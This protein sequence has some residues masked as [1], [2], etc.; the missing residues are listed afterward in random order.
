M[1]AF[2]KKLKFVDPHFCMESTACYS[3]NAVE[4]LHNSGFKVSVVNPLQIKSFRMSKMVRQKTDSSDA[5]VIANF[6]LQ[7]N[8]V[9]WIPRPC[10]NKELSEINSRLDSMKGKLNR[11]TNRLEKKIL[12]V[13][14]KESI[15]EEIIFLENRIKILE[16]EAKKLIEGDENLRCDFALLTSVKGVGAK[17]VLQILADMPD[18]NR[19]E[20][21]K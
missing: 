14:V 17:T 8:P 13:T 18:V 4:F 10:Q 11:L 6:C 1:I 7:N 3:E 5:E 20:N 16:N 12:N 19:F 9:A 21:A 15:D 2:A